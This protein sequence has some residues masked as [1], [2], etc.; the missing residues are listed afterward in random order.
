MMLVLRL[1]L[2]LAV[3]TVM[4]VVGEGALHVAQGR[5]LRP[6]S[7]GLIPASCVVWIVLMPIMR[8][9]G[10]SFAGLIGLMSPFLGAM[11]FFPPF[12]LAVVVLYWYVTIP[13]GI[14]TGLLMNQFVH[15]DEIVF[16]RPW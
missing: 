12:S 16:R 5:P 10:P 15:R 7:G 3:A 2:V 4:A 1:L 13:I 6:I 11:F 9:V 8:H 14:A